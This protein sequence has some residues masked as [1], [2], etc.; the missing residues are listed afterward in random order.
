MKLN[1]RSFL[2]AASVG[3]AALLAASQARSNAAASGSARPD[4]VNGVKTILSF[5]TEAAHAPEDHD[6]IRDIA[7]FLTEEK[8]V[9]N[10]HLT[11]DYARALK[12]LGRADV[13]EALAPHEIG[14]HCNHHG[15]R[16]WMAGYLEKLPWEEGLSRWLGYETPG[17]AA[18]EELLGRR[19]AYYTTEFA[20]APQAIYG[21]AL[22]GAG[23]TGY[24][25]VPMRQ[26]SAVWLCNSFIPS[27]ENIVGLESFHAPGDRERAARE[28]LEAGVRS[29]AAKGKDVLRVFLHSYK[30]YAEPPYDRLTMTGEIYK[31]D[32]FYYEDYPRDYPRQPRDR[33]LR[34]F[35]MF[36]RAIRRHREQSEFVTFS[37]Y[38]Q[39]YQ[40]IAGVWL[41]LSEVDELGR[42]LA[43]SLDAYATPRFS[44][45]PAE[46]FGVVARMLRVRAETGRFPERVFVRNLIGPRAEVL[47]V[48][49][50]CRVAEK[51]LTDLL[52]GLD[53]ELEISGA[54]PVT[55]ALA[56]TTMGPGQLLRGL[57]A[58]YENARAGR[59]PEPVACAGENLPE[60]ARE[61]YFQQTGFTRAGL[62]P[63]DFTGRNICALSRA[64]A[65]SWKPAVRVS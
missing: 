31:N 15:S 26:H 3:P 45:S 42:F 4:A 32:D 34:S 8:L 65:W 13:V 41:T 30:Y 60:I 39:G 20:K 17:M 2:Q 54:L 23:I 46:A 7:R 51:D 9:G 35:E 44:L 5:A 62:Y 27:V 6:F 10:F 16:P 22:L 14:F 24:S 25:D 57:V 50:D 64:Q 56:G 21:S 52:I 28:R 12:R 47:P 40:P 55:V 29:Q 11:G 18:V 49:P 37:R 48:R 36:K 58:L 19:P 43:R 33:F 53:R 1:R 38:R 63:A 61:G 59:A